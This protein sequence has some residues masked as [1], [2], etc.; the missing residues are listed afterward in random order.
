MDNPSSRWNFRETT[1]EKKKKK[2]EHVLTRDHTEVE[3]ARLSK[4]SG[5][6]EVEFATSDPR[7]SV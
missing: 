1:Q 4:P 3:F 2:G 6:T 5:L 7:L